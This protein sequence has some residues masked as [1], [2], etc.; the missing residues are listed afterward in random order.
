MSTERLREVQ[1]IFENYNNFFHPN[2]CHVCKSKD[3]LKLCFCYMISYCCETHRVQHESQHKE[4]CKIII[5]HTC[6][7]LGHSL[8]LEFYD[9]RYRKEDRST[10][11]EDFL[12][13]NKQNVHDM[14]S[15]IQ[16]YILHH[17]C[18]NSWVM[19]DYIYTDV[20]SSPL[21]LLFGI[22]DTE[23]SYI[24]PLRGFFIIHII[25]GHVMDTFSLSAWE[26]VLHE[27][28]PNTKLQILMIG[29]ELQENYY[30]VQLCDICI[31]NNKNFRYECH[32]MLYH[33]FTSTLHMRPDVILGFDVELK[34]DKTSAQTIKAI[35][36]QRCPLILTSITKCKA[37]ENITEIQNILKLPLTPT[38]IKKN[39]FAS[40]RPHRNYED[41]SVFFPNEYLII[42]SDL[43]NP[44]RNENNP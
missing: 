7:I 36:R 18:S 31:D 15:F 41:Y 16:E 22:Q 26:I 9:M 19:C 10:I 38:V 35:Q 28:C 27:L 44:S 40:C 33:N 4:I 12:Y 13:I 25:T 39:A 2:L 23:L 34:K 11:P 43:I 20:F 30:R 17:R 21:T 3:Q 5:S 1:S 32:C 6:I 24:L 42:Y 8:N 29:P 14:P 37:Q